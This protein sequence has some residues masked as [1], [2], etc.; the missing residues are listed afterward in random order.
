MP[1]VSLQSYGE[2]MRRL[3]GEGLYDQAIAMGRHVLRVYPKHLQTY[4]I[5][6]EACLEKGNYREAHGLFARALACDPEDLFS[7]VGI[8]V[9]HE[10]Q[11]NL[12]LAIWHLERAYELAPGNA[13][14]RK[15]LQRLYAQREGV[16]R[17]R[18]KLTSAAVARLYARSGLWLQAIQEY[19]TLLGQD[20]NLVDIKVA[21]AEALWHSDQR[22]EAV[23][24][25][26]EIL[27]EYPHCL[28]ANL[29]LGEIN[30]RGERESE[31]RMLLQLAQD[32]DPE[33]TVAQ[34][35]FGDRS[36]LPARVVKIIPPEEMPAPAP[37]PEV[38]ITEEEIPTEALADWLKGAPLEPL[39]EGEAET[40]APAEP[41]TEA[42]AAVAAGLPAAGEEA[43]EGIP[44][45]LRRIR[46]RQKEEAAQPAAPAEEAEEVPDWLARLRQEQGVAE[47]PAAEETTEELPL[48]EEPTEAVPG[49]G[50]PDWLKQLE[51]Q[52]ETEE[53]PAPA[54]APPEP[55]PEWLVAPAEE[56]AALTAEAAPEEAEPTEVELE[57][58]LAGIT[59]EAPE[60]AAAE[61]EAPPAA[62]AAPEEAGPTVIDLEALLAE[63]ARLAETPPEA[64]AADEAAPAEAIAEA[65]AAEEA[66]AAPEEAGPTVI[67]LEALLAE[68][69]RL[70]ET[71]PEAPAA[72]EAAPVAEAAP[73]AVAEAEAPAAEEAA[74]AETVA[75]APTVE[76]AAPA[77]APAPVVAEELSPEQVLAQARERRDSGEVSGAL[78]LYEQLIRRGV[79]LDKVLV[80]LESGATGPL[81]QARTYTLIGDLCMKQERLQKALEAYRR[82]LEL[83]KQQH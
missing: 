33:N 67:D 46:E 26:E 21:L 70:A 24:V 28:K 83:V 43:E 57:A 6:G 37:A 27:A 60:E 53:A 20:P 82:A 17:P 72:E 29:I 54:E 18:L 74:P 68:A 63:A 59:G 15:E 23:R 10:K 32:I 11:G 56:E 49:E 58:L 12:D 4:R 61:A 7:R 2:E 9:A 35:L 13:E 1:E 77:E 14:L 30:L 73:G 51:A 47:A 38:V 48:A 5:L 36:P 76:Q 39:R 71:P 64:P 31:G 75:E 78:D 41:E 52:A 80:D 40:A 65:P 69:A 22:K 79:L 45:W 8:A 42:A 19:R 3:V 62:E 25:C 66:E 16:A 81:A 50:I 55:L 44:D 34:K